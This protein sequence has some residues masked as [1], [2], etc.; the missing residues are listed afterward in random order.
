MRS[1]RTLPLLDLVVSLST[2]EAS[3]VPPSLGSTYDSVGSVCLQYQKPGAPGPLPPAQENAVYVM[4]SFYQLFPPLSSTERRYATL[5]LDKTANIWY[6][7][8]TKYFI[9]PQ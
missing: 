4:H 6:T 5:N 7:R 2:R 9:V 3:L 8:H 1:P